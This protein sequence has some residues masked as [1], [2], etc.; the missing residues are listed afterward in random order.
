MKS[1]LT[2]VTVLL[3][4][5][6]LFNSCSKDDEEPEDEPLQITKYNLTLKV[7]PENGGSVTPIGGRF[8]ENKSVKITGEPSSGYIFKEWKGDT[9]GTTNPITIVM[10]SNKTITIVFQKVDTDGDGVNDDKDNCS[11][12]P[13]GENVDANGCSASQRDTDNDGISDETDSCPDTPNGQSVDENGC[14][15]SQ[16]DTDGDGIN[17]NLDSCPNTTSGESVDSNGCKNSQKINVPDNNFEK[18]L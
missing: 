14:S 13:T 10:D 5:L 4:I 16:A 1:I 9:T 18:N 11:E 15:A 12:T 3:S 2:K 8:L 17:N 6:F 7:T